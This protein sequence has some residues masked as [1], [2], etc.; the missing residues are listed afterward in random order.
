MTS[1]VRAVD[2]IMCITPF[3]EPDARLATAVCA[4]GG[5]GV[6]DLGRGD[7][8]T[9]EA[10]ARL[11]RAAPGPYGVRIAAGCALTPDDLIADGLAPDRLG[12][13]PDTVVR[14]ADAPWTVAELAPHTR[15]LAEVTDLAG[16]R[17]AVAAGAHGL[18]ARG[19]ESGGLVGELSTFVLLQQLLSATELAVPVWAAGGIG[20]HTA[21]AAVA[22]GAAGV[23]L[24]SQ[25]ALLAESRLPEAT[26]AALRSLDGS[27]TAVVAGYRVLHRRGPDAVRP[28][29]DDPAAVA[30]L[31]GAEDLRTQLLPVG[32]DGFLAARFAE[33]WGDVR[34]TVRE[35]T[36]AIRGN[37][38]AAAADA[39][40]PTDPAAGAAP[41]TLPTAVQVAGP[42]VDAL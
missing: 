15:V 18:I 16:A 24:D 39:L 19:A 35:L 20:P 6:L 32:Q 23:V 42:A 8:R 1:P 33:R 7:R 5:L 14:A 36:A 29:A 11:R 30:A 26:A 12:P 2:L 22:G 40:R 9:R 3:G 13:A 27:E 34:R 38:A 25:L 37:G 4:A 28:P 10:L 21:A 31:L 17:A 41:D